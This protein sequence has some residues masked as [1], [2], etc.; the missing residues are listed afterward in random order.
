[1]KC[2]LPEH[3]QTLLNVGLLYESVIGLCAA[4]CRFQ[5]LAGQMHP[6]LHSQPLGGL[7]HS[8]G[9][10]EAAA[11]RYKGKRPGPDILGL[12]VLSA[13]VKLAQR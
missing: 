6:S 8:R 11:E 13:P 10:R 1:M 12:T 9:T 2:L 7:G 5:S 4:D 3:S